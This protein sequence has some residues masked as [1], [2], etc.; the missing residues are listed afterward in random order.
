MEGILR[1]EIYSGKADSAAMSAFSLPLSPNMTG[2]PNKMWL[3][4]AKSL[5]FNIHPKEEGFQYGDYAMTE[6]QRGNQKR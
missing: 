3:G 2:K 5:C 1:S 4:S 6:V